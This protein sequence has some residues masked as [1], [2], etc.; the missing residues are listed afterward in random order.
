MVRESGRTDLIRSPAP[1]WGDLLPLRD[2]LLR[3]EEQGR[4]DADCA[5]VPID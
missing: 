4:A 1:A 5:V 3:P 2:E